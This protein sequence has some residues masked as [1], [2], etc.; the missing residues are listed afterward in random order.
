L[1]RG[2]HAD[3]G[4]ARGPM[5][6]V[7]S[8]LSS[9]ADSDVR[10]IAVYMADISGAPAPDRTRP[11]GDAVAQSSSADATQANASGAAIY[12]AACASCHEG[13]RPLPYGGVN[14]ALSTAIASPDPRNLINIVLS[15]V[16]AVAGEASPIMPG[17]AANT[18]DAQMVALLS[19]LRARFGKQPA[20]DDLDKTVRD[21]RASQ[22]ASL[23]ALPAPRE[24]PADPKPGGKP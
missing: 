19:Y 15:G 20:W 21:A 18:D 16:P 24:A 1:R 2:W 13:S 12:A 9:V 11:A 6:E 22:T 8:N 10:A 3:H 17:F 5:A 23:A 14:L 4:T 7:V